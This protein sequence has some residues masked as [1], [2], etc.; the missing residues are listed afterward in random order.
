MLNLFSAEKA[1]ENNFSDKQIRTVIHALRREG[2]AEEIIYHTE[3][4]K[5]FRYVITTSMTNNTDKK[6]I[7]TTTSVEKF[8]LQEDEFLEFVQDS[9]D[10]G[11]VREKQYTLPLQEEHNE[12]TCLECL[13]PVAIRHLRCINKIERVLSQPRPQKTVQK[14]S[15]RT[16]FTLFALLIAL[17]AGSLFFLYPLLTNKQAADLTLLFNTVN[18]QVQL[19]PE[20]YISKENRLDLTLP[21]GRYRLQA[22]KP[23]FKPVRQDIF[24]TADEEV[25]IHLEEL[26][27]LTVYADMEGTKALLNKNI[28]GTLEPNKP[29]ELS[30]TRGEYELT[31]TNPVVSTPFQKKILLNKDQVIRAELPHPQLTIHTNVDDLVLSIGEEDYPVRNN[32]LKLKLPLG[33]YQLIARKPGYFP[34]R[35]EIIIEDQDQVLPI[36]M[37]IIER[38]LTITS[39]VE[40]SSISLACTNEQKYFGIASPDTPFQLKTSAQSCILLAEKQG[41]Q[42]VRQ[43]IDLTA[44][45]EIDLTLHQLFLITVYTNLD[46]STILLN[47]E[48]ESK[49]GTR[50]PAVFSIPGGTYTITASHPQ[51]RAP[52]E[53]QRTITKDQRL[54]IDLPLPRLTVTTNVAGTTLLVDGKKHPVPGKEMTFELPLGSHAITAQKKGY[55]TIQ[56]DILVRDG[57]ETFFELTQ[58]THPLSIRSNIDKTAIYVKCKDEKEYS[59]F[60]SPTA[61]FRLQA[62]AGPCTV[63]ASRKGYKDISKKLILPDE[64]EFFIH[65]VAEQKENT[66]KPEKNKPPLGEQAIPKSLSEV[67]EKTIKPESKKQQIKR[68]QTNKKAKP[69]RQPVQKPAATPEAKPNPLPVQAEKK[70]CQNELSVGMPELCD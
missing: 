43:E 2:K 67:K 33:R 44:D 26:H 8:K 28:I 40:N 10:G 69:P 48:K 38:Q 35:Q 14:S 70:G 18:V 60:S 58:P 55:I 19:G 6:Q 54:N 3:N 42:H 45:Q 56:R 11:L 41:Y 32:E 15:S 49:A 29:L 13:Q 66:L 46:L 61:P 53:Q 36:N 7:E 68:P 20:Q 5:S 17:I 47:N 24:L 65:L 62:V 37:E 21:L 4:K 25:G 64:K 50:T 30:L 22:A 52:V 59:G 39:N 1:L 57:A 16:T 63:S 34:V 27:T 31:L 51:A 23:G 9:L 12:Q